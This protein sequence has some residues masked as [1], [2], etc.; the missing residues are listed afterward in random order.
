MAALLTACGG[1]VATGEDGG[2]SQI[3][4]P[5]LGDDAGLGGSNFPIC[6]PDPPAVGSA[7]AIPALEG[8]RYELLSNGTT[9]TCQAFICQKGMWQSAA[10]GC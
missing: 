10:G 1:R 5:L 7:C 6:P 8:C 4:N 3:A 9:L 2:P